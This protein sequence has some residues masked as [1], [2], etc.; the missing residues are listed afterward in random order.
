ML[1][2]SVSYSTATCFDVYT[3]VLISS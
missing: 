2:I 1:T 3:G